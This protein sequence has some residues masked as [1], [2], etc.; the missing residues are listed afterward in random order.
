MLSIHS[1]LA[2]HSVRARNYNLRI[3]SSL[4]RGDWVFPRIGNIEYK[5]V[6]VPVTRSILW[7]ENGNDYLMKLK[8][9]KVIDMSPES[10]ISYN[11]NAFIML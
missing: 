7:I 5:S 3:V 10:S 11:Q 6:L 8:Y 2:S 9:R 4:F 1:F